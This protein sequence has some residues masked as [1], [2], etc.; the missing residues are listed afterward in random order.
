MGNLVLARH[1]QA[2]FLSDDYDKLSP[3]GETQARALGSFWAS[4]GV[5]FDAVFSGP[6]IRQIRTAELV[7]DNYSESG[8]PWPGHEVI[9]ELD[10]YDGQEVMA[11]LLP[12]MAE[13]DPRVRELEQAY[14]RSKG[15]DE[16]YK[17]FQRL[18]EVVVVAWAEGTVLHPQ[19]TA[20]REFKERV[21]RGIGRMRDGAGRG[22]RIV[23]FTS[24][25]PISVAMQMALG[26]SDRVAI[27]L[28]WQLR[29]ASVTEFIFS[30]DRFT[31]DGFNSSP[32]LDRELWTYR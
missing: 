20:W 29:N 9:P 23:A 17:S 24:G 26:V 19:V 1:G 10:E 25:G 12:I 22:R 27:G 32:H 21:Q 15:T 13:R 8:L 2:A 7:R 5:S 3:L 31:L 18:F 30:K 6:R 16:H 14:E 4:R 11:G 28:N